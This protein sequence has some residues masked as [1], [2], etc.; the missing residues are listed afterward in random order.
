MGKLEKFQLIN[1][2]KIRTAV[3]F[4]KKSH[5][6]LLGVGGSEGKTG[7]PGCLYTLRACSPVGTR[8]Q[9][10][11]TC[12]HSVLPPQAACPLWLSVSPTLCMW[13]HASSYHPRVHLSASHHPWRPC[14]HLIPTVH[15]NGSAWR[16][17]RLSL[18]LLGPAHCWC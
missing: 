12:R 15:L 8:C 2:M 13:V 5:V 17:C 1:D 14:G 3:Y 16:L 10:T 4:Y 9:E 7:R 11:A 18:L 6:L